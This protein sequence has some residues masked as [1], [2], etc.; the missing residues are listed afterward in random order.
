[1][2]NNKTPA[3][4]ATGLYELL[5]PWNS[6]HYSLTDAYRCESISGFNALQEKG[7]DVY[8]TFYSPMN[9]S[10]EEY[11]LDE[12]ADINIVTLMSSDGLATVDVPSSFIKKFP[13]SNSAPYSRLIVTFDLGAIPDSLN[14]SDTLIRAAAFFELELGA[15]GVSDDGATGLVLGEDINIMKVPLAGFVSEEQASFLESLR[16]EVSDKGKGTLGATRDAAS[17][18]VISG[19]G[20]EIDNL[21]QIIITQQAP[22]P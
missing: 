22:E 12:Q 7:V 16:K 8:K 14:I 20:A 17:D 2:R 10:K 1:M 11:A 15:L 21:Q 5:S 18:E 19:L 4:N 13:N 3:I 6:S 9:I